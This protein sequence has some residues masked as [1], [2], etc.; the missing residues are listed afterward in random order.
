VETV[1]LNR[2]V[3]TGTWKVRVKTSDSSVLGANNAACTV[4]GAG[5]PAFTLQLDDIRNLA[6]DIRLAF[7][8]PDV[9]ELGH[10]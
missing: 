2:P 5:G 7:G 10:R 9:D 8:R 6:P 1:I 3:L 4:G